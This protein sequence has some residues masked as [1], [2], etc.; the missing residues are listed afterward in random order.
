MICGDDYFST[1]LISV[2]NK[3]SSGLGIISTKGDNLV[4]DLINFLYKV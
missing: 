4:V 1:A 2:L 3:F